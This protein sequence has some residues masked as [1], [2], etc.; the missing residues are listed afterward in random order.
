M[1]LSKPK[2]LYLVH[3]GFYDSTLCDGLYES[4]ANFF[5]VAENFEEAKLEA[6][7]LPEFKTKK[8]HVDGMQEVKAVGGYD[9]NPQLNQSLAG[10]TLVTNYKQR[11]LAPKPSESATQ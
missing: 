5:V 10:Q 1:T 6:K 8:M 4:D 3:C 11:D 2:N 9:I 7:K